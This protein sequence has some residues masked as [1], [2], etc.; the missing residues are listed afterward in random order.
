MTPIPRLTELPFLAATVAMSLTLTL[1]WFFN[2]SIEE[3]GGEAGSMLSRIIAE[4]AL[5]S[6]SAENP[7]GL[8]L[9]GGAGAPPAE[10]TQQ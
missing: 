10:V 1:P 6:R 3:D 4:P 7:A 2:G 5:A 8:Q 9:A